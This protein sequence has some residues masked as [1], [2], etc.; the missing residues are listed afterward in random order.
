[1]SMSMRLGSAALAE[2]SDDELVARFQGGDND[3]L[4]VLLQ[5]YRRFTRA[6]ARGYFLIGADSDDIEQEG[7]I[8][9]FKAVRDFRP[10]RQASFRAFAE[11]CITRQIITAIKTATR[12]KH[13]PLNSY[14]SLSGTRPGEENGSGTVEEVLEAKGLIDPIE[15]IISMEDLRSMRRMMSEMLSK[16]EVEVL[17]LYVEGKSYQEIAEVLGRHVK[18]IDNA[19]QRIKRKLDVHL[20]ERAAAEDVA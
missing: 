20:A 16:L 18:S 6:K 19:L 3:S 10:D 9:L 12:Q 5:R 8:G 14:L 7:M 2:L 11:L 13:Q 15:F 1:M 4:D 17:R